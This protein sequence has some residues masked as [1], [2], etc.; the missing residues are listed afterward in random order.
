MSHSETDGLADPSVE[1]EGII[2]IN[3]ILN[4]S[5]VFPP[6]RLHQLSYT[7]LSAASSHVLPLPSSL[8]LSDLLPAMLPEMLPEQQQEGE[9]RRSQ[10]QEQSTGPTPRQS[11]GKPLGTAA[12][13]GSLPDGRFP[14]FPTLSLVVHDG[15]CASA[16]LLSWD[17]GCHPTAPA[18]ALHNWG[19]NPLVVQLHP[20]SKANK[21]RSF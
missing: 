6:S 13:G 12:M 17:M 15:N 18:P 8:L 4:S 19:A 9:Q 5:H 14:A 21:L 16:P 1:S 3:E 11:S 10:C 20:Q 7:P 2:T